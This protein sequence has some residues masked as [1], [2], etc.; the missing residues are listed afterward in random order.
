MS[1]HFFPLSVFEVHIASVC[2]SVSFI[3]FI[4]ESEQ[5][6]SLSVNDLFLASVHLSNLI[7]NVLDCS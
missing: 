5:F 7:Q 1:E 6:V 4:Y 3:C 2:L